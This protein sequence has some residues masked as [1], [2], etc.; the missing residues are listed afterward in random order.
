MLVWD[1]NYT[2]LSWI[3]SLHFGSRHW[4]HPKDINDERIISVRNLLYV[5]FHLKV[6]VRNN[7]RHI[8][9]HPLPRQRTYCL[10]TLHS[11]SDIFTGVLS[12]CKLLLPVVASTWRSNGLRLSSI[13]SRNLFLWNALISVGPH[14]RR[15]PFCVGIR[16]H[17]QLFTERL[18]ENMTPLDPFE[19]SLPLGFCRVFA[20]ARVRN[21]SEKDCESV[22][23]SSH[24]C[25]LHFCQ[26]L[27]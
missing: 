9:L 26:P 18:R 13:V 2:L 7:E 12:H 22:H 24:R 25:F 17:S 27:S 8:I 23:H 20:T 11:M 6:S 10:H 3:Q 15:Q 14:C 5:P 4:P 21:V 16:S 1:N 19:K